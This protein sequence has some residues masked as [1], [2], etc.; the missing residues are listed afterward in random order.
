VS[1]SAI[2]TN[3]DLVSGEGFGMRSIN[4]DTTVRD[5]EGD[6]WIDTLAEAGRKSPDSRTSTT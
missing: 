6:A 3:A 4:T 5:I 2:T 1:T